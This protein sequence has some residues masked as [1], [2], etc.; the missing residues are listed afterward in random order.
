[1]GKESVQVEIFGTEY[2]LKS[3]TDVEHVR[4]IAQMVDERMRRLAANSTIKSPSKLAVLTALNI[5]DELHQFKQK[6]KNLVDDFNVK[7]KKISERID[8]Y[9][10][11]LSG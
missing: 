7:S 8:Y 4:K 1:M 6:Y 9:V 10:N 3:D 5:A 11:N 2:T